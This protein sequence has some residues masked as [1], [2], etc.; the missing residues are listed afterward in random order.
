VRCHDA[1]ASTFVTKI[2]SEILT[3]FHAVVT[4]CHSSMRNWLFGLLGRIL[5]EQSPW[6]QRKRTCS[7]LCSS[8]VSPFLGLGE[9]GL[10]VYGSCF[11]PQ[12]LVESLPGSSSKFF[13]RFAQNLM[14]S[15]CWI[16]REIASG[17]IHNSKQD[18]KNQQV[19]LSAWNLVHW[20]PRYASIIIYLSVALTQLL[21]RWHHQSCKLWIS[22]RMLQQ[23]W[24][25]CLHYGCMNDKLNNSV[26]WLGGRSW[27]WAP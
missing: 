18:V 5:C 6:C 13:P 14:L 19:H 17:Q 12:T 7:R 1:T 20:L 15:L 23:I 26:T 9:S 10:S 16:H 2:R 24:D 21:Y 27:L 3:H 8:S 11:L 4:E 22:H 25:I